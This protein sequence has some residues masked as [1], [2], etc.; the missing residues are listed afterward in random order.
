[1]ARLLRTLPAALTALTLATGAQAATVNYQEF[2]DGDLELSVF[3]VVPAFDV[4][5][6]HTVSGNISSFDT[7]NFLFEVGGG[8]ALTG[9]EIE[10]LSFPT[11]GLRTA[12]A[13]FDVFREGGTT[14]ALYSAQLDY[15]GGGLTETLAFGDPAA[16]GI[17]RFAH[18]N[19]S[20]AFSEFS[21][22]GAEYTLRFTVEE[23]A[24]SVTPVPLPA[25]VLPLLMGLGALGIARRRRRA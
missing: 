17:F 5:G 11:R 24:P 18:V 7:D 21:F 3:P 13:D 15:V 4:A 16:S 2:S 12:V 8:L 9:V 6:I 20:V 19:A 10:A 22:F 25:S 1:M 14:G 23:A